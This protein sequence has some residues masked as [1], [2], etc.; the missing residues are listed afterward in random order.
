MSN[1]DLEN[2]S[3][4]EL[5]KLRK[6]VE[7]A[8]KTFQD[9]KKSEARKKLEEVAR[10]FGFSLNEL[11]EASAPRKRK[12]AEPKY[13]NPKDQSQTWTGR[14][15]KPGWMV[16]ALERGKSLESMLIKR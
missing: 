10:D 5:R 3:L 9:R 11:A 6:D 16:A 7:K 8:I 15:R 4:E 12:S 2:L 13:A 1:F 14:G